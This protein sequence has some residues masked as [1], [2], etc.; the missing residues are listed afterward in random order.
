M[1]QELAGRGD[2]EL[3]LSKHMPQLQAICLKGLQA[4][5][6]H[7]RQAAL[8]AVSGFLG[9]HSVSSSGLLRFYDPL[10][11]SVLPS[12]IFLA[13]WRFISADF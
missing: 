3:N 12:L 5:D 11:D 6:I 7:V 8:L 4:T 2:E 13:A 9:A 1:L 10:Y